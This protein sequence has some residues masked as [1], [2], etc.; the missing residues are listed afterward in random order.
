VISLLLVEHPPLVRRALVARLALELDLLVLAEAS[1]QSEAVR[2]A[3]A[4]QPDV[5]V[6]DVEM[7][8]LDVKTT[9][10]RL[11]ACCPS[12]GIVLLTLHA[13][14]VAEAL[15]GDVPVIVGKHHGIDALLEAIRATATHSHQA[16]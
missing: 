1:H 16:E 8:N 5:V 7:P 10:R 6:L 11:R 3:H 4:L 2:R 9:V 14:G 15:D 12:T 13:S